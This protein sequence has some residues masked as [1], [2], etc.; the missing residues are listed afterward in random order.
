[1]GLLADYNLPF[2]IAFGA[3]LL[4]SV[5]QIIGVGDLF[6][7]DADLDLDADVDASPDV[8]GSASIMG[9]ITTLLGL[10][11]VP[12]LIW[13]MVFLFLFASIGV[14]LQSLADD[15]LGAPLDALLAAVITFGLTLPVTATLVRPLGRIMPQ[16]E[17]D[18]VGIDSL[19]GR[20]ATITTGKARQ[21]YPA[22]AKVHD[23]YGHVHHVM[24]EPHEAASEMHEGDEVLLVRRE[25]Q[26]FFGVPLA[27]RKLAPLN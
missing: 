22:R 16:D 25:G 2:A 7:L 15:F 6:D 20:R 10:G 27:E 4:L 8:G 5:M 24:V 18:A 26:T 14:G 1:M 11:R 13:L 21:G 19:V 3:M 12:F 17:T 9:G 23:R